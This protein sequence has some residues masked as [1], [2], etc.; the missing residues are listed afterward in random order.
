MNNINDINTNGARYTIIVMKR[1][2][3]NLSIVV[4]WVILK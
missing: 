1:L 4:D 2:S 3:Y